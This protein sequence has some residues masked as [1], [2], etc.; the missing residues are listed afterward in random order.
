M[1]VNISNKII[2]DESF[3]VFEIDGEALSLESQT[4][5]KDAF[6]KEIKNGVKRF[7]L[8]LGE[9]TSITSSGLG[10]L[11]SCLNMVNSSNGTLKLENLQ[12]KILNVF[13]ITKL[14]KIFSLE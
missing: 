8:D 11:I 10:I 14:D 7:V 3:T 5:F 6:E 13:R 4:E 2:K 9:V 12:G 1:K